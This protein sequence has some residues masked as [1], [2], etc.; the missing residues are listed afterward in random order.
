VV[1][2]VVLK[3]ATNRKHKV[4]YP[5]GPLARRL[6]RQRKLVPAA[7]M[8]RGIRKANK[9]TPAPKHNRDHAPNESPGVAF[10]PAASQ[11]KL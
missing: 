5:A 11:N 8:D 7:L 4:R 3:A 6:S 9:L 10:R 2:Q 1:A